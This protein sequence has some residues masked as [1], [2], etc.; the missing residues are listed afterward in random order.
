MSGGY[1]SFG[2]PYDPVM[3]A[4]VFRNNEQTRLDRAALAE[5][6]SVDFNLRYN[7]LLDWMERYA[8]A[9][10][11]VP[12]DIRE[13]SSDLARRREQSNWLNEAYEEYGSASDREIDEEDLRTGMARIPGYQSRVSLMRGGLSEFTRALDD[14]EQRLQVS[15]GSERGRELMREA[16]YKPY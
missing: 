15:Y 10:V 16:R 1:V 14:L 5:A 3:N 2:T 4:T 13:I 8:N 9:R 6:L 7:D 12:A 11:T